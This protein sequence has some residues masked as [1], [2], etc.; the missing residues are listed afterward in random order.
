MDWAKWINNSQK[1]GVKWKSPLN[2]A[3]PSNFNV[4]SITSFLLIS[5]LSASNHSI[6]A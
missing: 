1:F 5:N 3:T 4:R 2:E 6:D